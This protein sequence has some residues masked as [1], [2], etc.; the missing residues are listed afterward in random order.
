MNVG[1]W[2]PLALMVFCAGLAVLLFFE[3][4]ARRAESARIQTSLLE[5]QEAVERIAPLEPTADPAS[6]AVAELQA[7]LREGSSRAESGRNPVE[8]E[9]GG[10]PVASEG[11]R[12][13]VRQ[14]LS[15]GERPQLD[16]DELAEEQAILLDWTGSDRKRMN[17]L[18]A[19]RSEPRDSNPYSPEV[20]AGLVAWLDAAEDPRVRA[21]IIHNLHRGGASELQQP[22]LDYLRSD[23]DPDV[24]EAAA[25]TLRYGLDDPSL[26]AALQEAADRDPDESVRRRAGRSLE[27]LERR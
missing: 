8:S 17:A 3:S 2:G 11:T 5:L 7:R 27:K 13:V 22:L 12:R 4:R 25:E 24:R 15:L 1:R 9:S 20:V 26:R 19:L 18:R 23:P 6:A 16:P 10:D 21:R 14:V